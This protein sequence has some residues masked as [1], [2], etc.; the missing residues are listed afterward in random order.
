MRAVEFSLVARGDRDMCAFLGELS[1][2][3]EPESARAAGD[4]DDPAVEVHPPRA[5]KAARQ[6]RAPNRKRTGRKSCLLGSCHAVIRSKRCS[7]VRPAMQATA[8]DVASITPL[9]QRDFAFRP[10]IAL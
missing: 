9:E 3:Q 8:P 5:A 6:E 2:E 10:L 4:H 1:G 7:V